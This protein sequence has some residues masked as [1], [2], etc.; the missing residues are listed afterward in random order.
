[1]VNDPLMTVAETALQRTGGSGL[2]GG[3]GMV[4]GETEDVVPDAEAG[5]YVLELTCAGTGTIKATLK[6]GSVSSVKTVR[7]SEQPARVT[8]TITSKRAATLKVL[9]SRDPKAPQVA[10]AD[11]LWMK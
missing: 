9:M 7:C 10:V 1:M 3:V 2:G 11:K 6:M 5:T 4:T 8:I